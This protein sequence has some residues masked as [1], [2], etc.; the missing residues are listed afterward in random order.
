[1]GSSAARDIHGDDDPEVAAPETPAPPEGAARMPRRV[2][3]SALVRRPAREERMPFAVDERR[4]LAS[5][6]TTSRRTRWIPS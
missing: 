2:L 3:D 5:G 1:M 4:E 6:V